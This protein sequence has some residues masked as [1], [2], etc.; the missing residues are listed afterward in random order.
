M[1]LIKRSW[2][3]FRKDKHHSQEHKKQEQ[4]LERLISGLQAIRCIHTGTKNHL[5]YAERREK[6]YSWLPQLC[7]FIGIEHLRTKHSEA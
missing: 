3:N 6:V 1:A 2:D 7:R 4:K 5:Q